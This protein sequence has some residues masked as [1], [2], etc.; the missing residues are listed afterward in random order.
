[1]PK[2]TKMEPNFPEELPDAT[3]GTGG[4]KEAQ[5]QR[6]VFWACGA[7]SKVNRTWQS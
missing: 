3:G 4:T 1:M 2:G 6:I 5:V 7:E